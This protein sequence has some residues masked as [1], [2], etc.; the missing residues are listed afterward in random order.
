MDPNAR[1]TKIVEGAKSLLEHTSVLSPNRGT[2]EH[3]DR[4]LEFGE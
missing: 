3:L 1:W 2:S 4:S